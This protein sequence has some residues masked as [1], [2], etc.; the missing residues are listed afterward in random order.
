MPRS[1]TA[2]PTVALLYTRVSSEEQGKEGL[3]LGAQL[4][5][6]RRYAAV[7]QWFIGGEYQDVMTGKRAD[8][9]HYQSLLTEARRLRRDGQQV[10]VVCKW[11]H[12]FGRRVSERVR[13]WEELD[14]LG[15]PIHS[16]A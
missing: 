14:R 6:C 5:D 9:P 1:S 13:A 15:A 2:L 16:V 8:R 7:H 10:V 11:L 12:R 4:A 3:S